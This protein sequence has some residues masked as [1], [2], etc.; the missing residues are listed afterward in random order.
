MAS[1]AGTATHVGARLLAFLMLVMIGGGSYAGEPARKA[2]QNAYLQPKQA[3]RLPS[4]PY[5]VEH[6]SGTKHLVVLGTYHLLVTGQPVTTK[7]WNPQRLSPTVQMGTLNEVAR[8]SDS[9]RDQYVLAAIRESLQKYDRVI[10][11]FGGA[12][13]VALES[14]LGDVFNGQ[15]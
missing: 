8:T 2:A 13:V 12:H 5:V 6:Q 14:E 1:T 9:L 10:V 7:T 11:V 4:V 15:H 3:G